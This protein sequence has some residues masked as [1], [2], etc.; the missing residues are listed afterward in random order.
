MC[1]S[2]HVGVGVDPPDL[3]GPGQTPSQQGMVISP[4]DADVL[5]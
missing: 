5:D 4:T 2:L 1:V 3:G